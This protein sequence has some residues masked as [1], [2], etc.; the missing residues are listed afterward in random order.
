MKITNRQVGIPL[1]ALSILSGCTTSLNVQKAGADAATRV[2]IAYALP[3][4]Q[5]NVKV[6]WSVASCDESGMEIAIKSEQSAI[7]APDN[8]HV[9][10]IDYR[11]LDS[12]MKISS[13]KTEFY[14]NGA[15]KSINAA[16][17]DR[18]AEVITKTVSAIGKIA[19]FAIGPG[20][21]VDPNAPK[22]ICSQATKDVLEAIK[23]LRVDVAKK[24]GEIESQLALVETLTAR[25]VRGGD[26]TP[27]NMLDQLQSAISEL[28]AKQI[29]LASLKR[30]L[31][32]KLKA[33][34]YVI[35]TK[36]PLS[37]DLT[38]VT[39]DKQALKIPASTLKK[40]AV[41][42]TG[43]KI[44]PI[45]DP[46]SKDLAT[47]KAIYFSLRANG[48]FGQL[49]TSTGTEAN[50]FGVRYRFPAQGE[51]LLCSGGPCPSDDRL[52]DDVLVA[53]LAVPIF[54]KGQIFYLPFKSEAFGNAALSAQFA[55]NGTL[56]SAGY[57][58]KN[59]TAEAMAGAADSVA[60]TIVSVGTAVRDGQK[61][62]LD[63][64]KAQTELA[65]AE[66]D[67]ADAQN[68]LLAS[69]NSASQISAEALA[70]DTALKEAELANIRAQLALIQARDELVAATGGNDGQ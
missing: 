44:E 2:G 6:I 12:A 20:G 54:Q 49:G 34:T 68:A 66:K 45:G 65:K 37:S 48:A 28:S 31:E 42:K 64:I 52:D 24:T 43:T 59:A 27:E 22:I 26:A 55:E 51:L 50:S 8:N 25:V 7:G 36:W 33:I 13:V 21:P 62:D 10:T 16:A 17:E 14:A 47:K 40:W 53:R 29:E 60:D 18:T 23:N 46:L 35:D 56:M 41:Q 63:K 39:D 57:E 67:L 38:D 70:A 58:K 1:V 5:F 69:P 32:G 4:T 3:F 61:S 30:Q 19:N 15:L 11:S 9:Y